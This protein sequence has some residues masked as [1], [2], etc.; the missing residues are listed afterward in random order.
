MQTQNSNLESTRIMKSKKAIPTVRLGDILTDEQCANTAAILND[1]HN[2]LDAVPKL[3][4]YFN[5][6]SDQLVKKEILPDYLAYV[7]A[8]MA[9]QDIKQQTA[10]RNN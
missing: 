3:K 6:L 7:V 8:Y 5:T 4:E 10:V 2:R 9:D 1:F